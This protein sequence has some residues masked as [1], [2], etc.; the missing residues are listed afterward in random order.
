MT[1][2]TLKKGGVKN[3]TKKQMARL[4]QL[5]NEAI[6][7]YLDKSNWDL[8]EWLSDKERVEYCKLYNMQYEEKNCVCG[9]HPQWQ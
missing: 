1:K 4:E 3:M 9:Q 6:D 5:E 2:Y 7:R 8:C